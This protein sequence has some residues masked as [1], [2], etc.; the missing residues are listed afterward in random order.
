MKLKLSERRRYI[1]IE[2]P[3]QVKVKGEGWEKELLIKNISPMGLR[4]EIDR[5]L[6]ESEILAFSLYLPSVKEPITLKGKVVWQ[7]RVS[8][9][10]NAPYDAGIEI[11]SIVEKDKV[12]LLKYLCDLLYGASYKARW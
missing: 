9:E 12:V 2:A 7:E 10:D 6:K 11:I 3:L 1:R 8:I 5:K 4:F